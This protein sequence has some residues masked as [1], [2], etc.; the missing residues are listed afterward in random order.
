MFSR[1]LPVKSPSGIYNSLLHNQLYSTHT[2][3]SHS[4]HFR[5]AILKIRDF[6]QSTHALQK[7]HLSQAEAL[8]VQTIE[9]FKILSS[10][11]PFVKCLYMRWQFSTFC[12]NMK[13]LQIPVSMRFLEAN[14]YPLR[15]K[16]P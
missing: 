16:M 2:D 15:L 6:R 4:P 10:Q 7:H 3:R 8:S 11:N 5:L 1:G 9:I 14:R 13:K 12:G